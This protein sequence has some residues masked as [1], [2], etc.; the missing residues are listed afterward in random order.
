MADQTETITIKGIDLVSGVNRQIADSYAATAADIKARLAIATQA[1]KDVEKATKDWATSSGQVLPALSAELAKAKDAEQA[2]KQELASVEA[3]AKSNEKAITAAALATGAVAEHA[4]KSRLS[5][6]QLGTSLNTVGRDLTMF[7]TAPII[8]AAV[9]SEHFAAEFQTQMTRVQTLAGASKEEVARMGQEVLDLAPKVGVGPAELAKGLFVVESAGYKGAEAM[10]VL[11]TA[12]EMSA[13]GM[14]KTEDVTRALIGSM[15]TYTKEQLSAAQAGD[16]LVKTVQ[17]GNMKIDELVPA[18]A[19][20]NPLA[21]ALGISFADVTS[22][23][24]TFT[25]MGASAETAAT[26]LRAVLSNILNDSAKTEKG[27]KLLSQTLGD[28]SISMV[29]FRK[30]ISEQG[31]GGALLDLME[32]A[33]AAGEKGTEALNKI[34]PN[35]K[36]LT[37]VLAIA[38]SQGE[39]YARI[40]REMHAANGVLADGFAETQKTFDFHWKAFLAESEKVGILIGNV[41][42]PQ[43]TKFFDEVVG[44]G[45]QKVE[46][47]VKAWAAL[48]EP[49]KVASEV[50]LGLVA[51]GG[52]VLL[53]LGAVAKA[54]GAIQTLLFGANVAADMSLVAWLAK[55]AG[56]AP[57]A[58]GGGA[59]AEAAIASGAE[60]AVFAK[61]I[62]RLPTGVVAGAGASAGAGLITALGG[63]YGLQGG[64]AV[65]DAEADEIRRKYSGAPA[66]PGIPSLFQGGAGAGPSFE[67]TIGNVAGDI[68]NGMPAAAAATSTLLERVKALTAAEREQIETDRALGLSVQQIAKD[69]GLAADVIGVYERQNKVV[70][71]T[72]VDWTKV[73]DEVDGAMADLDWD[74]SIAQALHYGVSIKSLASY[75]GMT[76]G[77]IKGVR[78]ELK[79]LD[80]EEKF[81]ESSRKIG[82][83]AAAGIGKSLDS[84][85]QH[86]LRTLGIQMGDIGLIS[87]PLPFLNASKTV[88]DSGQQYTMGPGLMPDMSGFARL[89]MATL[90]PSLSSELSSSL[91]DSLT[92]VPQMVAQAFTG[93]GGFMGAMQGVG[94][95]LGA[96]IGKTLG[97]AISGLG[98]LGGP[99]GAAIGSLAGPM[100][101]MIAKLFDHKE[102]DIAHL[103]ANDYGASLSQSV[104]K[105]IQDTMASLHISEQAATILSAAEIFPT[106]DSSNF[107]SAMKITR[108]AFSMIQTGQLSVAQGGKVLDDM[109]PKLAAAGTDAYG[110]ISNS[111]KELIALDDTLGT[112]S[113]GIADFLKAQASDAAAGLTDLANGYTFDAVGKAVSDAQAKVDQLTKDGKQGS[114]EWKTASEELAAALAS[115]A[116]AANDAKSKLADVSLT[117][118]GTFNAAIA[119]GQTF[120]QALKTIGPSLDIIR[121]AYKDLGLEIKGTPIEALL[122]QNDV[123]K[124][125]PAA[126]TAIGGLT[127]GFT[128]QTNISQL[129]PE[130]FEA[131]ERLGAD[132]YSRE[133][134]AAYQS[135]LANGDTSDQTA[136]ALMPMQQWLHEAA[137]YAKANNLKL[138]AQT[139]AEIDASKTLGIWKDDVRTDAQRQ[140][141]S[142]TKL[143]QSNY[144]LIAA[145]SGHPNASPD[146]TA[147]GGTSPDPTK[148]TDIGGGLDPNQTSIDHPDW[149][150]LGPG[151]ADTPLPMAEGGFGTVTSPTLFLAGERGPEQFAFSGAGRTFAQRQ[152]ETTS[153]TTVFV[154]VIVNAGSSATPEQIVDATIA[155]L[156]DRVRRNTAGLRSAILAALGQRVT[157]WA[158]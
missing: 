148:T 9:A 55:I 43:L 31:L 73:L 62:G 157:T 23:I 140:Y 95:M 86:L 108:D 85:P 19:R 10:K 147:P 5:L 103:A 128:A 109:W 153:E 88:G 92:S 47:L 118:L 56:F 12:S 1:V 144:D 142:T 156:P 50:M 40:T 83:A 102:S 35:V 149:R 52:P 116:H 137:D 80:A 3:A 115:Q 2:L 120:A 39:N 41:L 69:T 93:G 44:P 49:V 139:Q 16:I 133:Q 34:F 134:N 106:V 110:R 22:A 28:T 146:G 100:I 30:D 32:K 4:E 67:N 98:K 87:K 145:L 96:S 26:G 75:F 135:A 24:A 71:E 6:Q 132:L 143:I 61:T 94:S 66:R 64:L 127:A 124:F 27:F 72:T 8:G 113:K 37:E 81:I 90:M 51:A 129:T 11:T 15:L 105:G 58:L 82:E 70:K 79:A 154:P 21:A 112:H 7:V 77:E 14:G 65:T 36:A 119:S 48:P 138:D 13:L 53:G 101:E 91:M 78:N 152:T 89:H 97:S 29:N 59:A 74:G 68:T 130:M 122:K 17:L 46:S 141:D 84:S 151:T 104:N 33:N 126:T 131:A 54:V 42:L 107:A 38:G 150:T 99:I 155:A 158:A 57:A 111:L 114:A 45:A 121:K 20:V 60:G 125:D 18:L 123:A 25:H 136:Q 63:S 117:A 76:Q